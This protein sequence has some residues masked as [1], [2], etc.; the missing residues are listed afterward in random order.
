MLNNIPEELRQYKSFVLWRYE[1]R[2]AAKPTKVLYSASGYPASHS[3]PDHW[4]SYEKAVEIL[5]NSGTHYSGIGFV[6]SDAD[7]YT[8]IDLDDAY[9]PTK[10]YS[11][12]QSQ[13]ILERQLK[14]FEMFNSYSE[15]SPS[16]KGLHIICKGSVKQGRKRGQIEIYSSQ[17]F[18]TLTG[19]VFNN[20]P[21][22]SRDELIETLW[23]EMARDVKV[24]SNE[25]IDKP[26][27]M[28]D[29]AVCD[30]AANAQNGH[31]FKDLWFGHWQI[32]YSSQSEADFAL[33]DI[34]AFYTQN[35]E[36]IM[37]MFR[38][39]ALGQRFKAQRDHYVDH[40]IL[41]SFDHQLPPINVDALRVQMDAIL[42][43]RK[44]AEA[45]AAEEANQAQSDTSASS[46]S[47]DSVS[48]QP[49]NRQHAKPQKNE[50]RYTLP[51]GLMGEIAQ[52][53]YDAAPRPCM[54]IALAGAI[55]LMAGVCGRAYNTN[56]ATGLNMY[57][58]LA[59]KTGTG[60]EAIAS[61]IDRLIAASSHICSNGKLFIGP[62]DI[63]SAQALG[64]HFHRHSKSFVA[65]PGEIGL[66]LQG[67]CGPFANP[68]SASVRRALLQLF[69]VSGKGQTFK[70]TI[71]SQ[72]ENSTDE[73]LSPA[74]SILGETTPEE[75]YKVLDDSMITSGLVPRF[76]IIEYLGRR[77]KLNKHAGK[78]QPPEGLIKS[79]ATVCTNA[80]SLNEINAVIN[81]TLTPEAE[82]LFDAY[83]EHCDFE[84]DGDDGN[85]VEVRRNIWNRAH[86][87]ALKLASLVAV[88]IHPY[89]PVVDYNCA[90]W[91]IKLINDEVLN[92]LSRF[93]SGEIGSNNEE[94]R[95][96]NAVVNQ[97]RTFLTSPYSEVEK[98][99]V[100]PGMH[101][102]RI[103]P[104]SYLHRRLASGAMFN[105]KS[106]NGNSALKM[107]VQALIDRGDIVEVPRGELKTRFD[108]VM[109]AFMVTIPRT[110]GL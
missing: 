78:V 22:E 95:Q 84:I 79:F 36:Q 88:G 62:G 85:T 18:M 42:L 106:I 9:E 33:I 11:E 109:R 94:G 48:Q 69:S 1:D 76:T 91:A 67:I 64:K 96:I 103:I 37:R 72:K 71:N 3:N 4:T 43:A 86:L 16:G 87:K 29:D 41:R 66:W 55:G 50:R 20:A 7:P 49:A 105:G 56:T 25:R 54:E 6:L 24:Y 47:V 77:P 89:N 73:S 98:Y 5:A 99:T 28:E 63:S 107:A 52:F 61:G 100:P 104:W 82:D 35:R 60:K 26:Q 44:E 31:K 19:D 21:I 81:V 40:M 12:A 101:A 80:I 27:T 65:M 45:K 70:A 108:T 30:M 38:R 2:G 59:A 74:L 51:P 83:N 57:V 97:I 17:R 34:I 23:S 13:E 90:E 53:I 75:F 68:A 8:F 14:V 46:A 58:I 15:R 39:S 32:Y 102:E 92:L 93:D 110:F 10:G